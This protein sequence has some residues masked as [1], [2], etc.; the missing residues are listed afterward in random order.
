MLDLRQ[1]VVSAQYLENQLIEFYQ[2]L[3][4]HSSWQDLALKILTKKA[5]LALHEYLHKNANEIM[6][7]FTFLCKFS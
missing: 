2:I 1:N 5:K 7:S 3:Y 4:L 6:F